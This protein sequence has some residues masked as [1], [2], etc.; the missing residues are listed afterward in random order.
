MIIEI[1]FSR[2]LPTLKQNELRYRMEMAQWKKAWREAKMAEDYVA[3]DW[4]QYKYER[5]GLP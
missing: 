4:L 5:V 2:D 1:K 3:M